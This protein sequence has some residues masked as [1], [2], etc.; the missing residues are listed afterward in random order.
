MQSIIRRFA[1]ITFVS[2]VLVSAA[3]LAGCMGTHS[4]GQFHGY[5]VGVPA[6]EI[7]GRMG[8]PVAV[9]AADPNHPRWVYEKKT[10]DPDNMNKVDDKTIIILER[11]DGKLVGADILFG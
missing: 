8:K 2:I 10:F 7:E 11:K 1:R 4:R 9:D 3:F 6:E 5:V